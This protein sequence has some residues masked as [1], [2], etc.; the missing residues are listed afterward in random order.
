MLEE[1]QVLREQIDL[2]QRR[3]LDIQKLH[4]QEIGTY[5]KKIIVIESDKN[6]LKNQ[7]ETLRSTYDDLLH[8]Y[9]DAYAETQRRIP[10]QEH[11]N[12]TGELKRF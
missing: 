11:L 7:I 2:L 9:N 8:K 4:I 3:L 12:Q 5:S 10:L 6:D 1:N